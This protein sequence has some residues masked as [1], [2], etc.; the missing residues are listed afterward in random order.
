MTAVLLA[1]HLETPSQLYL[2]AHCLGDLDPAKPEVL[3]IIPGAL[4]ISSEK[5]AKDA[6]A[7]V[8]SGR[9]GEAWM[10]LPALT[11]CLVNTGSA[12]PLHQQRLP[13]PGCNKSK[14][15]LKY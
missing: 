5:E 10:T 4:P 7:H 6:E 8:I 2:K 12:F 1:A 9:V 13:S 3:A 11:G 14:F 15:N